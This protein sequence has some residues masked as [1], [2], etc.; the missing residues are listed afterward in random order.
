[1]TAISFLALFSFLL[2]LLVGLAASVP[3][4]EE[5]EEEDVDL[6]TLQKELKEI[7]ESLVAAKK[8]VVRQMP[9]KP[10]KQDA[11]PSDIPLPITSE[12]IYKAA[13]AGAERRCDHLVG[14]YTQAFVNDF[15]TR[16]ENSGSTVYEVPFAIDWI[17]CGN[18]GRLMLNEIVHGLV[19]T[20]KLY[21]TCDC[22]KVINAS[23]ATPD[24]ATGQ[25]VQ[26]IHESIIVRAEALAPG[27]KDKTSDC[28]YVEEV[29][30]VKETHS[31]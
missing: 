7:K 18:T 4:Q 13:K 15:N 6:A 3:L 17:H 23:L 11:T 25:P 12:Q 29:E 31:R 24:P 20:H 30:E 26:Q 2:L 22:S 1:M 8:P 27:T 10:K 21:V 19:N 9:R 14:N 5:L 28:H 16:A